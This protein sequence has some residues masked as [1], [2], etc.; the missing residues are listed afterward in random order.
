MSI[1]CH[2]WKEQSR[3]DD[4]E[5]LGYMYVYFLTGG[6]LPW[7][8]LKANDESDRLVKVGQKKEQIPIDAL[9]KGLPDEFPS[10]LRAVRALP[11]PATPNYA[12]LKGLFKGLMDKKNLRHDRVFEWK[13]KLPNGAKQSSRSS[14]RR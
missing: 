5:A 13:G 6:K 1:N 12:H 10:Y 7:S 9:C 4:L 3:R 14:D 8:G 2:K 11:F